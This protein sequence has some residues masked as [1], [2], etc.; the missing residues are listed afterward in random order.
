MCS[1]GSH[2]IVTDS[3]FCAML[4][5]GQTLPVLRYCRV[6][7]I[8]CCRCEVPCPLWLQLKLSAQMARDALCLHFFSA[9]GQLRGSGSSATPLWPL[10][11][12]MPRLHLLT[13]TQ[14]EENQA[15]EGVGRLLT[16]AG[17][18]VWPQSV[19]ARVLQQRQGLST[20]LASLVSSSKTAT[21]TLLVW[22]ERKPLKCAAGHSSCLAAI[23]S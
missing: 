17:A 10:H 9:H 19:T 13:R 14:N 18:P 16:R 3:G 2:R 8:R 21:R 6:L 15:R 22:R 12:A 11:C 20:G 23:A 7:P 4:A 5:A 1:P